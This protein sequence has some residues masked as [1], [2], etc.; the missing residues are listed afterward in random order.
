MEATRD[1]HAGAKGR[2]PRRAA[3]AVLLALAAGGALALLAVQDLRVHGSSMAPLLDGEGVGDRILA[4][5]GYYGLWEPRRFDLVVFERPEAA[6]E[7]A[8]PPDLSGD[9]FIKRVIG[10]PG[11][12]VF[13]R[14]GDI[15]LA[16]GGSAAALEIVR[17]PYEVL[18]EQLTT[19][20][21]WTPDDPSS[22]A[23]PEGA[24]VEGEALVLTATSSSDGSDAG[25]GETIYFTENV[26][27]RD[28]AVG[29][30]LAN[31]VGIAFTLDARTAAFGLRCVLRERGDSFA[32]D[33]TES[34]ARI[35]IQRGVVGEAP[36]EVSTPLDLA[37]G[38]P[39]AVRFLNVDDRALLVID[40]R[41]LLELAYPGN[42][43]VAGRPQNAPV[44]RVESG[45]VGLRD[46]RVECDVHYTELGELGV[47]SRYTVPAGHYFVLGDNSSKS[48]DSR[49]FGAIPRSAIRSRPVA[50]VG[51]PERRRRL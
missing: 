49:H 35:T 43:E 40:D 23:A 31:D 1:T 29:D 20:R 30:P 17:V 37:P 3:R 11:E 22:F 42:T 27:V 26:R 46:L 14:D 24:V 18:R 41:P 33:L 47:V 48:R 44:L 51:P 15:Y 21:R 34:E 2:R 25:L 9:L 7:A 45:T 6:P 12:D 10:L 16:C 4:L 5:R 28:P 19:Y 38:T 13:V 32:L 50:I 39:I 8:L 36:M